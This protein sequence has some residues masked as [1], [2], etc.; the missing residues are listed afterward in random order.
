MTDTVHETDP[1]HEGGVVTGLWAVGS[2]LSAALDDPKVC[3]EM[4]RDIQEWFD[5]NGHLRLAAS[6]TA[7][8]S[9]EPQWITHDGGPNPVPGKI[10]EYRLP[11]T[12]V[13]TSPSD[14]IRWDHQ[15]GPGD[16]IA[17]RVTEGV[18]P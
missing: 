17:Y 14:C 18:K 5:G 11:G 3:A 2:W 10:V 16:I 15:D 4:K 9:A 8:P 13:L 7:P 6:L 1:A 12:G